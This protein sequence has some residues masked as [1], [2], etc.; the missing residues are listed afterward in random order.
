MENKDKIVQELFDIIQIKKAEIAK[1]E[2]PTWNTNCLFSYENFNSPTNLRV[3]S[4][5]S[6]IVQMLAYL[7]SNEKDWA[8]AN[9]KLATNVEFL[10]NGYTVEEWTSDFKTRISQISIIESKKNLESLQSRLD[11]L[12]SKEMREKL[13]LEAIQ[14]EINNLK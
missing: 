8:L 13:E 2:K 9:E 14:K 3:V 1:A 12:V 11:K 6:D 10:Y 7:L 4:K 5:I